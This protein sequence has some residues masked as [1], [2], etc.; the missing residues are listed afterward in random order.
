MPYLSFILTIKDFRHRV[1][2]HDS[3]SILYD[4]SARLF[5]VILIDILRLVL[6][7]YSEFNDNDF[8]ED[9]ESY[10]VLP[11]TQSQIERI[12]FIIA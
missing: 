5:S 8:N 3:L 1:L 6:H 10:V 2:T 12:L 9:I 7:S 11:Q 4:N